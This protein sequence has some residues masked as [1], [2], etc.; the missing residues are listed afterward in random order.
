MAAV[1]LAL[2]AFVPVV[3]L[4]LVGCGGSTGGGACRSGAPVACVCDDG[5]PGT[6]VCGIDG[7]DCPAAYA[8]A[9]E[10][11]SLDFGEVSAR[12][13]REAAVAIH[14][15][16]PRAVALRSAQ[17]FGGT[18]GDYV[19]LGTVPETIPAGGSVSLAIRFAPVS[20][21]TPV[22][23]LRVDSGDA[24]VAPVEVIVAAR[25]PGPIL[26]CTPAEVVFD[27]VWQGGAASATVVC[28]NVGLAGAADAA[29]LP[30]EALEVTGAAFAAEWQAPPPAEGLAV[31]EAAAI[32][33]RFEPAAAGEFPGTLAVGGERATAHVVLTG[34][35]SPLPACDVEVLPGELRV[36]TLSP[37][38]LEFAVRNRRPDAPCTVN[39]VRLCEGTDP[40]FSL[41]DGPY[42]SVIVPGG[43]ELRIPV[44]FAPTFDSC[45]GEAPGCVEFELSPSPD[46]HRSI[47]LVCERAPEPYVLVS[48]S[49]VDFGAVAAGCATR[50]RQVQLINT[51]S[52]PV[53]I[54]S[55]ELDS[56]SSW[57]EFFLR[58]GPPVGWTIPPGLSTTVTLVYR[59]EDDGE[60]TGVAVIRIAED[61]D[62]L[63]VP[64]VGRAAEP[65]VQRDSFQQCIRPLV[66][67]LVVLDNGTS[68]AVEAP[69][70]IAEL[71]G[72]PARL[73]ASGFDWHLAVTTTGLVAADSGCPGGA[74]GGEDGRL[75]PVDGSRPRFLDWTTL[76]PQATW[77]ANLAVGTCQ[78]APPQALE[79]AVRALAPPLS[80][81][82]DDPR[83]PEPADGNLGFLR[84]DAQLIVLIVS[85]RADAS[86]GTDDAYYQA[87]VDLKGGNRYAYRVAVNV[88]TGDRSS[89]CSVADGRA[90]AAGDRLIDLSIRSRGGD[91][92]SICS[93][94]WLNHVLYL[95]SG[96]ACPKTC[97]FLGNQPEDRNGNRVIS[98][99]DGEIR[100][101]VNGLEVPSVMAGAPVWEYSPDQIAVCF[102]PLAIPPDDALIQVDYYV[103][104]LSW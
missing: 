15:P 46:G 62:P 100:V 72:L 102:Q 97:F 54:E 20:P 104:C 94:G 5:R 41:A 26:S 34:R 93:D 14:N 33:V 50:D 29:R 48:P 65:A 86:P 79:A 63:R 55:V 76:D 6:G 1:S 99:S 24:D 68:M 8:L 19:L 37:G 80:T 43:G 70:V 84:P 25:V 11:A 90:A 77:E 40:A 12:E 49:L 59:P 67:V 57:D 64:L 73:R 31:G 28:T 75:Y 13:T 42:E 3:L 89:G 69:H 92:V 27:D 103:A 74:R 23:R 71:A 32:E 91:F 98:A 2:R 38:T 9:A 85:D 78:T 21:G 35:A 17:L 18:P 4:A 88:V 60:D 81:S 95:G 82:A 39:D 47:P 30:L 56:D 61:P 58:S 44:A 51:A 22:A 96:F 87:L 36:G 83:H 101:T 66:D 10:P 7:C 16:A 52:I 53:H 45:R